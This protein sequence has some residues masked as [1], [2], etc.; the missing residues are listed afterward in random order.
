MIRV[1]AYT[2]GT[3]ASQD[4]ADVLRTPPNSIPPGSMVWID[5]PEPTDAEEAQV[6]KHWL[7]VHPL[8]IDDMHRARKVDGTPDPHYP[9]VEEY[10]THLFVMVYAIILPPA[11]AAPNSA[12]FLK[13]VI[14]GQLNV[15]LT[16]HAMVTHHPVRVDAIESIRTLIQTNPRLLDRGPDFLLAMILDTLIRNVRIVLD[17]IDTRMDELEERMFTTDSAIVSSRLLELRRLVNSTRRSLTHQDEIVY[18]LGRGDYQLVNE[19]ESI[20]YREVHDHHIMA[21]DQVD[22]LRESI[23]GLME[24]Y[25][26]HVSSRL[27]QVMRVL[28]VISTIFLPITFITNLYGMN[29]RFMPELEWPF[30]YPL[31]LV[32]ILMVTVT[33]LVLFR[34]RGW[35]G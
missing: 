17:R 27:N 4:I 33:M 15:I 19:N 13:N 8:V 35:L 11:I 26:A 12:E 25:F 23:T 21:L 6:L 30:G 14:D 16:E 3:L 24:V 1:T 28:T 5:M 2:N 31:V 20:Y 34:R 18:Q 22:S 7:N 10:G 32:I 9:S 29:F